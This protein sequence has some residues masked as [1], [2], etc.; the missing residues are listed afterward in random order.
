MI[1]TM[2]SN[3][4]MLLLNPVV[5]KEKNTNTIKQKKYVI[6]QV[7]FFKSRVLLLSSALHLTVTNKEDSEKRERVSD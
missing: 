6:A 4:K 2:E 3:F 5:Q 7:L 1:P